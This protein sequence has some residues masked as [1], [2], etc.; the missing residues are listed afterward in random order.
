[1]H[2][3]RFFAAHEN[4]GQAAGQRTKKSSAPDRCRHHEKKPP[5]KGSFIMNSGS[6]AANGVKRPTTKAGLFTVNRCGLVMYAATVLIV[7]LTVLSFYL[8]AMLYQV[9]ANHR[10]IGSH[11]LQP[12]Q[13]N[14]LMPVVGHDGGK[15]GGGHIHIRGAVRSV[16]LVTANQPLPCTTRRGDWIMELALRNKLMYAT[17]HKYKTW[18]STELVSAWDLEAAWNKIPLL[19]ILMHP[20]SPVTQGMFVLTALEPHPDH[21]ARASLTR[22]TGASMAVSSF[23]FLR[24]SEWLLWMDDDAIFT[25]MNFTFPYDEYDAKGVNLVIWG[26][27]QRVFR[28]N[29]IQGLNT[30]VFLLR[31][32]EW[33]RQLMAEVAA[34]ATPSIRR[35]IGNKGRIAEQGALTW[36]LHSQAAK[37]K[38][39]VLLERNFTMN[40]NW[41]DYA[42]KWVKGEKRLSQS[43]WGNDQVPF[44][45]QY[46]GCQVHTRSSPPGPG[47]PPPSSHATSSSLARRVSDVPWPL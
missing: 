12:A 5:T 41:M 31:K 17:L 16:M 11:F 18:W 28:A 10:R 35:Q 44:V 15:N 32:C 3:A 34:L 2:A 4:G 27:P 25:D 6:P 46:A 47:T 40:G 1:M 30:G 19:Y 24:C 13:A 45:V 33:S 20:D 26:D 14:F 37:W 39:K 36:V 23:V 21:R 38:D 22:R 9:R 7:T 8:P 43:V 42:G 29:D